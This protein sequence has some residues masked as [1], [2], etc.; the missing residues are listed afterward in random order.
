MVDIGILD[1]DTDPQAMIRRAVRAEELGFA[2]YFVGHHRFTPGFGQTQHP[3]IVLSAIAART[4][5]I[6]LGTSIFLLPLSH[7]LEVAEQ[8]ASLDVLSAGRVI[9]GPGLGYRPYEFQALGLPYERRGRLMSECLE[10]VQGAWR[11]ESFSYQGEFFSFRDVTVTPRPVQRPFIP[12]WVGAN[13]DPAMQRAARLGDGWI[14]GFSDR[15]PRL[16]PKLQSYRAL[17]ASHA[18]PATV[19]LMR[20]VGLGGS[21][22]EVERDWLPTVYGMLRNYAKVQAPVERGDATEQSLKA[23]NRGAIRLAEMGS[24]MLVAG[25]PDDVIAGLRRSIVETGC[26]H[27]VIYTGGPPA[28]RTMELFSREVMPALR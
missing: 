7:P 6:R 13:T 28:E 26:E 11:Q 20:L 27:L 2:S 23:A 19:C 17:A 15:L 8:V 14:V 18:R 22:E 25:T 4:A 1:S 24:D 10:V 3:W 12:I 5:R 9:F 21:R 16:L